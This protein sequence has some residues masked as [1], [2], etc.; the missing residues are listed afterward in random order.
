MELVLLRTHS[1]KWWYV[2]LQLK[3]VYVVKIAS[4]GQS[5]LETS[6]AHVCASDVSWL[7]V[8]M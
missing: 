8:H 7:R 4:V 2:H 1:Q 6:I 3:A 5:V